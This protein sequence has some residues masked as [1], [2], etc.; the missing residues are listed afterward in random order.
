M[1]TRETLQRLAIGKVADAELLLSHGRYSNAYY[2]FGYGIEL[3]FKAR[4]ARAFLAE[5]IPDKSLVLAT[6]THD[7]AKLAGLAQ[8]ALTID[9]RRTESPTFSANWAT[10]VEW[11][12]ESRYQEVDYFT[13]R[14]MRDAIMGEEDGVFP[15]LQRNW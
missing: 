15:W 2:L 13:A 1:I 11:S 6:Y 5:A 3:S 7:L 10:V 8:L 9:R 12:E 14:N 4:I